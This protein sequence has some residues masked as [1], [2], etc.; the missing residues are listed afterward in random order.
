MSEKFISER[1]QEGHLP[2]V[3]LLILELHRL[4]AIFFSSPKFAELRTD[5]AGD[6]ISI[7]QQ[8]EE[9]EITRIL[10]NSAIT[11]RIIDD[12][13]EGRFNFNDTKCGE[14]IEDLS[15]SNKSKPLNI[16]EACNKIIH[17]KKIH[18]DT[19]DLN[20]NTYRNPIMYFYGDKNGVEWKTTLN[21][22]DYA[23]K[24]VEIINL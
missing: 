12:R 20:Y 3:E 18:F 16:R 10:I 9:E 6:T 4:L 1:F 11:A 21:I 22:V 24:Y 2:N 15:L 7:L 13:E 5:L 19:T 8:F 14:L 17:A 23:M